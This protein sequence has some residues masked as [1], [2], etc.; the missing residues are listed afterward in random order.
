[1]HCRLL[2]VI[3]RHAAALVQVHVAV[4]EESLGH[5]LHVTWNLLSKLGERHLEVK[6][7][8]WTRFDLRDVVAVYIT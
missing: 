6:R 1:M 8:L 3:K 7:H 4:T 2:S 5:A